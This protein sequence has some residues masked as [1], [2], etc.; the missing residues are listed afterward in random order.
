MPPAQTGPLHW[1]ETYCPSLG[2]QFLFLDPLWW[3]THLLSEGAAIVLREAAIA[4]EAGQ[5]ASFRR[6]I[7]E[8]GGWPANLEKLVFA[9]STLAKPDQ[10]DAADSAPGQEQ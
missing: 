3:D 8:A 4:L 9:L 1:I 7:D 2:G 10:G 5:F 6:E